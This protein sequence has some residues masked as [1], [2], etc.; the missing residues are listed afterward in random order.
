LRPPDE[1][2]DQLV[3]EC[4]A[5]TSEMT[6][7]ERGRY[8]KAVKELKEVGATA[9]DISQRAAVYRSTYPNLHVTPNALV[10]HWS[11]CKPPSPPT[12]HVAE[13]VVDSPAQRS[14]DLEAIRALRK[15]L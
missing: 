10:V 11:R 13:E 14:M 5:D 2:W 9:K 15:L 8:N 7:S 12:Y 4:G 1:I 3:L 6:K